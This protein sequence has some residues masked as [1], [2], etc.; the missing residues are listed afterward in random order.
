MF[1][2]FTSP[3]KIRAKGIM[4]MNQR[5]HSYIG[6]YNDRSKFPLVD[7]KLKTKQIA[8]LHGATTPA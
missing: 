8:E 6:K 3:F 4:G 2:Q 5:N 7:D 1:N